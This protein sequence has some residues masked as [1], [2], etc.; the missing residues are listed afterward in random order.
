MSYA[1]LFK[2]IIIGDTGMST[3]HIEFFFVVK[4]DFFLYAMFNIGLRNKNLIL[5]FILSI[6]DIDDHDDDNCDLRYFN[7]MNGKPTQK[8]NKRKCPFL[9]CRLCLGC[10]IDD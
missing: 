3:T 7:L 2:Y 5:F 8:K 1:Y 9:M 6:R 10:I 4:I